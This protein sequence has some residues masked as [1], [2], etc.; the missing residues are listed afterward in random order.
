MKRN[1]DTK[2]NLSA[3][4]SNA[5]DMKIMGLTHLNVSNLEIDMKFDEVDYEE[6]IEE[7]LYFVEDKG[8]KGSKSQSAGSS[9]K[10][11]TFSLIEEKMPKSL[12]NIKGIDSLNKRIGSRDDES[13]FKSGSRSNGGSGNSHPSSF[14]GSSGKSTDQWG[15]NIFNQ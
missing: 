4:G 9:K 7:N 8:E 12:N 5:S 2:I 13:N 3:I 6:Q 1:S 15:W 11:F 10:H 14:N